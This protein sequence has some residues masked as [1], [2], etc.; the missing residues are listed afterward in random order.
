MLSNIKLSSNYLLKR[1]LILSLFV[2][3]ESISLFA[4]IDSYS[5]GQTNLEMDCFECNNK[6]WFN[7]MNR[8]SVTDPVTG[9]TYYIYD[10]LNSSVKYEQLIGNKNV[11][12]RVEFHYYFKICETFCQ[13]Q[14]Q[15]NPVIKI[16][17]ICFFP[18][19]NNL[20]NNYYPSVFDLLKAAQKEIIQNVNYYF[21]NVDVNHPLGQFIQEWRNGVWSTLTKYKSSCFTFIIPCGVNESLIYNSNYSSIIGKCFLKCSESCCQITYEMNTTLDCNQTNGATCPNHWDLSNPTISGGS[22]SSTC[23]PNPSNGSCSYYLCDES[24]LL[25][26]GAYVK[27]ARN[28]WCNSCPVDRILY[29]KFNLLDDSFDASK[30]KYIK[31]FD[32]LGNLV[33]NTEATAFEN[34][35]DNMPNGAYVI[36]LYSEDYKIIGTS[37]RIVNK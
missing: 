33:L 36:A 18:D 25:P 28:Q 7:V 14:V 8:K 17:K 9:E 23:Q 27:D 20:A 16:W 10:D 15:Y 13:D 26:S 31:I 24:S 37:K 11:T 22:N 1:L 35:I 21:Q 29:G 30:A 4:N 12:G 32:L 34:I 5:N 3:F 2:I 19:E 6:T